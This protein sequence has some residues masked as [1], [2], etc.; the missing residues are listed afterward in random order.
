M[1][2]LTPETLAGL[3]VGRRRNGLPLS[4]PS[5]AD[6]KDNAV[7]NGFDL[8]QDAMDQA[9]PLGTYIRPCPQVSWQE[10]LMYGYSHSW[11]EGKKRHVG[12]HSN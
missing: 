3:I 2:G 12:D 11:A 8:H 7:M 6:V 9:C 1:E 5:D 10:E 4:A